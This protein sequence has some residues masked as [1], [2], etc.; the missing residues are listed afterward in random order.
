MGFCPSDSFLVAGQG[1]LLLLE[2]I[3]SE[4]TKTGTTGLRHFCLEVFLFSLGRPPV[5]VEE[6]PTLAERWSERKSAHKP[7]RARLVKAL[8]QRRN[9][10]DP[11]LAFPQSTCPFG[12]GD[13]SLPLPIGALFI[14]WERDPRWRG[15]CP[16]CGGDLRG[17][18][19]GGLLSFS[20][21]GKVCLDCEHSFSIVQHGSIGDAADRFRTALQ[22]T[23]FQIGDEWFGGAVES[24]GSELQ[25]LLGVSYQPGGESDT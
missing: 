2:Q 23:E 11:W 5:S 6:E 10:L 12:F 21:F 15:P 16:R 17:L 4:R 22:N 20:W 7:V 3:G 24:D 25:R 19:T 13:Q 8:I 18:V 14:L 1:A 9:E